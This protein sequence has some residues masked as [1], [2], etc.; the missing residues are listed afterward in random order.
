MKQI[1]VPTDFSTSSEYAIGYAAQLATE[2]GASLLLLHIYQMP[3][4][5]ADMPVMMVSAE[6]IKNSS[7]KGLAQA[8]EKIVKDHPELSIETESRLGDV[9]DELKDLCSEKE[10]LFIVVG[11]KDY[12]G[13]EKFLF[14]NTAISIV[15]HSPVPVI[16]VPEKS[17][18]ATPKNLV[19]ATDLQNIDEVPV[20]K[21]MEIIRL[22]KARLHVV[23]IREAK[24]EVPGAQ[25]E[26]MKRLADVQPMFH[27]VT[28]ENVLNGLR[29]YLDDSHADMLVVLPHKHNLYERIFF[30]LHTEGLI[31]KMPVPVLSLQNG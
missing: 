10:P 11:T 18:I 2:L 3:V 7:D 8:R 25:K 21:V 13:L 5:M 14:G 30:K 22:L 23:H 17:R 20:E 1:V 31:E 24:E 28:D 16:S 19:M 29:K 9:V 12:R 6:E 15:R 4:S 27:T 26:L